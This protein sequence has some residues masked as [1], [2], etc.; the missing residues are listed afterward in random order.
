MNKKGIRKLNCILSI[1][2]ILKNIIVQYKHHCLNLLFPNN[3]C[4]L[5][6]LISYPLIKAKGLMSA[7][8]INLFARDDWFF[9]EKLIKRQTF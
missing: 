6:E 8:E 1:F 9:E 3:C 5:Q 4:S 7:F 2:F